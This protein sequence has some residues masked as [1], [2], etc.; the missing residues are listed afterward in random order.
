MGQQRRDRRGKRAHGGGIRSLWLPLLGGIFFIYCI[1]LV[2]VQLYT[3]TT[4]SAANA[5]GGREMREADD[6]FTSAPVAV[7]K[8]MRSE[9]ELLDPPKRLG[10]VARVTPEPAIHVG[11]MNKQT[12]TPPTLAAL[13]SE[14]NNAAQPVVPKRPM[15]PIDGNDPQPVVPKRPEQPVKDDAAQPPVVAK[16][17]EDNGAQPPVAA[18][19]PL[20]PPL[21]Q[22]VAEKATLKPEEA[23]KPA[24]ADVAREA[25]TQETA[26]DVP[27]PTTQVV[28]QGKQP[29]SFADRHETLAGYDETIEYLASYQATPGESLFLFFTCSDSKFKPSDWDPECGQSA[30]VIYD[31]FAKSPSTNRLVTVLAGSEYFWTHKNPFRDDRDLRIKSLPTLLKWHGKSGETSGMLFSESLLDEPF[32]RYLFKNADRPDQFLNPAAMVETKEIITVQTRE[33]YDHALEEYKQE[34]APRR[35]L[36]LYFVSGRIADNNRPWCPYCRYSELPMEYSFYAF[37]PPNALLI[38][39]EVTPSYQEWKQPNAYNQDPALGPLRGV[40]GFF[41]TKLDEQTKTYTFERYYER[42]DRLPS[43]RHLF[44]DLVPK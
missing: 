30:K 38:R 7:A 16:A 25:P 19:R 17:N 9:K 40:P 2:R 29:L 37:A 15:Q 8:A 34:A 43:L 22:P 10:Q 42:F 23:P 13:E 11:A 4:S 3:S 12:T 1:F 33:E 41:S 28:A 35:P 44:L 27:I 36:Y 26:V 21:I 31:V 32:L 14:D 24:E 6:M 18:K 20:Q 5:I 39:V